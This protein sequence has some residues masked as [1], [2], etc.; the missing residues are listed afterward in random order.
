MRIGSLFSGA[1]GG[2]L[3]LIRAGH[4]ISFACEI[5][6]NARSIL[7]Y[8]HPN[9]PIYHD[10]REVT[11]ERLERDRIP[12]PELVVGGSPCQ[13]LSTAGAR[14]G[15]DGE[16]SGLFHHQ[17]RIADEVS[18]DWIIWENVLGAFSSN[19]GRD[20][21]TVLGGIT[22]HTPAVPDGG[23]RTGGVCIGPKRVA[24]WRVCDSQY[25]GV[26]QRR[27]RIFVVGG[28]RTMAR[29]TAEVL[30]ESD[31]VRRDPP[32][33]HSETE[34][35]ASS[36]VRRSVTSSRGTHLTDLAG[37][38]STSCGTRLDLETDCFVYEPRPVGALTTHYTLGGATEIEGAAGHLVPQWAG[39]SLGE[40]IGAGLMVGGMAGNQL[41]G[42]SWQV[43]VGEQSPVVRR[44]TPLE[45]ERL[46]GY[47]DHYTAQGIT[48]DGRTI[49][50]ADTPR[51]RICGNGIVTPVLEWIGRRLP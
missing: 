38:L 13:D 11:R 29:R 14:A 50:V 24:V 26:P 3:G 20:F 34:E 17:C 41:E 48:D 40:E 42:A 22:G 39:S 27:R 47:P 49:R 45:C 37:T 12:L 44:L 33:S 21:A 6:P 15:L 51:Y 32:K 43:L 28:P 2:D 36:P 19:A 1:G 18:A 25:F 9:V 8:H 46:M 35:S 5:D 23:W 30:F 31:G 16:R 7:R 10:V 4:D